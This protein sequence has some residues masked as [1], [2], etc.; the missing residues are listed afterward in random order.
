MR[1]SVKNSNCRMSLHARF[2][3]APLGFR[4]E[5]VDGEEFYKEYISPDTGSVSLTQLCK[6]NTQDL[7]PCPSKTRVQYQLSRM[8][9][10]SLQVEEK[11]L[12]FSL[13]ADKS[14]NLAKCQ[15]VCKSF[16][17]GPK[18]NFPVW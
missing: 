13:C 3:V 16:Q 1:K 8:C 6:I 12:V 2:L 14:Y 18:A 17:I 11:L 4:T 7:D 9:H 5:L 15:V 10:F